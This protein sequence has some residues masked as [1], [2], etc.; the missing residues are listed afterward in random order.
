MYALT[1]KRDHASQIA[2][3]YMSLVRARVAARLQ[4][5]KLRKKL[6][7]LSGT[8]R[9]SAS[10]APDTS[11]RHMQHLHVPTHEDPFGATALDVHHCISNF[12]RTPL[13]IYQYFMNKGDPA[14]IVGSHFNS[15]CHM[16]Q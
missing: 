4:D 15:A 9:K 14:M 8:A 10:K 6:K 2:K 13:D 12:R 7:A 16:V 11:K 5:D 3:C 1:N